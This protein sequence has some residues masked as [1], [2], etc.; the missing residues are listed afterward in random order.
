MLVFEHAKYICVHA[1]I[2]HACKCVVYVRFAYVSMCFT[3]LFVCMY[4]VAYLYIYVYK[5]ARTHACC[6]VF[7]LSVYALACRVETTVT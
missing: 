2:L 3:C 5:Y 1:S 6:T 7:Q 4:V